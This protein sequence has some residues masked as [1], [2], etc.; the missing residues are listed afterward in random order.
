MATAPISAFWQEVLRQ[1]GNRA[2][3]NNNLVICPMLVPI[4]EL[5]P[6]ETHADVGIR[7]SREERRSC[8]GSVGESDRGPQW[9]LS[10]RARQRFDPSSSMRLRSAIFRARRCRSLW[11]SI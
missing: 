2:V 5:M 8:R 11:I 1:R 4:S 9:R 3:T 10:R 6:Y 7:A